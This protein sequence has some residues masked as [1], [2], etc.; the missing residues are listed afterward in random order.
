MANQQM[1][2]AQIDLCIKNISNG[3][4]NAVKK[5]YD[6]F[7]NPIYL[8]ALSI[9]KDYRLA[10]DVLQ[11]TFLNIMSSAQ[12]YRLGTNPK[13]WIFS[14]ARNASLLSLK[15]SL[16]KDLKSSEDFEKIISNNSMEDDLGNSLEEL[17]SLKILRNLEREIVVL[18]V[19]AGLKQTEISKVLKI[20]YLTV[21]SQ[22]GYA[23]K[24]LKKYYLE[25]GYLYDKQ[26]SDFTFEKWNFHQSP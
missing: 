14:L 26:T 4:R 6:E 20:P 23:L 16:Y 7:S 12:T 24:K 19:F 5:L 22:Y 10:E 2:K 21:R 8:F 17:E 9:V 25:R 1:D 18:Y 11:D 15:K 3:D 13:A